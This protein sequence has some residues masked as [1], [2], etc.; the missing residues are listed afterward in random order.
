MSPK[1]SHKPGNP[2]FSSGPSAKRPGWSLDA[3]QGAILGRSHR[4]PQAAARL[5]QS[6]DLTRE[7]LEVPE[8]FRVG[9][10]PGSDTGAFET[11]LWCLLGQREVDV[12]AWESFGQGW[13]YDVQKQLKLSPR[14]LEAPFGRIADLSKVDWSRDVVTVWNGTTSGVC[15][16]D[17]NWI[18]EDRQGLCIVDGT[19]AAF[20]MEIPWQKVD[21]LSYSWQKCLGSEGAH[22]MLVMSPRAVERV[23]SFQPDR[24]LP[25]LFWRMWSKGKLNE[26]VF[27]GHTISTPSM[28]CVEDYIDALKWAKGI[29]GLSALIGRTGENFSKIQQWVDSDERFDFVAQDPS[30][31][32]T[33]SV[34][35]RISDKRFL[36]LEPKEQDR[37]LQALRDLLEA[38]RAV[39]DIH[40]YH[41]APPGLRIWCGPTVQARDVQLAT[42][43]IGWA[44]EQTCSM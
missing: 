1:P 36:A 12:L 22:G 29:G 9:I 19:S 28:L 16:P 20:A 27:R 44:Y 38:E 40:P 31:R 15:I 6:V 42:E 25:K 2:C 30:C 11:A 37:R 39:Y 10:F 5:E 43:W 26:P 21:V 3:L 4:I 32:S 34:C 14:V 33:T 24:P 8:D 35:L 7:V 17:G 41:L 13:A 18:A 23:E